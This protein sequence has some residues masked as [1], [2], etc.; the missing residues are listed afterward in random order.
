MMTDVIPNWERARDLKTAAKRAAYS[1]YNV[2][3]SNSGSLLPHIAPD[4]RLNVIDVP[5]EC[6]K[7]T[8]KELEITETPASVLLQQLRTGALSAVDC[9]TAF[10]K[11]ALIADQLINCLTEVF[12]D[13]A[14]DSA[15]QL[16]EHLKR[17]GKVKGPLHG[18][19]VSLKDQF[20]IKG[21]PTCM[22][23]SAWAEQPEEK[24][25]VLVDCLQRAGAVLYV[26][27]NVGRFGSV[28]DTPNPLPATR[29]PDRPPTSNRS[30]SPPRLIYRC[31][32]A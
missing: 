4:S 22:G 19:P 14:I 1:K 6:G 32:R 10:G 28:G 29:H 5:K 25:C 26:R 20:G 15:Q 30:P 11:R 18:L 17:T 7:L 24:D 8:S 12:L 23:Y 2:D 21:L 9:V 16:D 3:I 27:T 31:R 13:R